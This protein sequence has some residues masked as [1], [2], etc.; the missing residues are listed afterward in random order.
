[1]TLLF[2]Y[3]LLWSLFFPTVTFTTTE[4][5]N[6]SCVSDF[7][8]QPVLFL[9]I[10]LFYVTFYAHHSFYPPVNRWLDYLLTFHHL[11]DDNVHKR[12]DSV[13]DS[14]ISRRA[15]HRFDSCTYSSDDC[16]GLRSVGAALTDLLKQP[17]RDL[18]YKKATSWTTRV[19]LV[20]LH[21]D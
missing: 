18:N 1:M 2:C 15:L 7:I 12:G 11:G 20:S 13:S 3:L 5:K 6:I 14:A 9:K 21:G 19:A 10:L 17:I 8:D 16:T 4:K